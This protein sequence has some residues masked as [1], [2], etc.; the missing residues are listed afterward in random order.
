MAENNPFREK[1][2]GLKSKKAIKNY[3]LISGV[4]LLVIAIAVYMITKS[5]YNA[6][7]VAAV[8]CGNLVYV[9]GV[10]HKNTRKP[11]YM[12]LMIVFILAACVLLF[13]CFYAVQPLSASVLSL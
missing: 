12:I 4:I 10:F 2:A 9:S 6:G 1:N 7:L 8:E 11:V 3:A 13:L 5:I